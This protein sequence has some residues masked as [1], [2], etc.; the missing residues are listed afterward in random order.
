VPGAWQPDSQNGPIAQAQNFAAVMAQQ[1]QWLGQVYAV[2]IRENAS[3]ATY[4]MMLSA[5]MEGVRL[6]TDLTKT[7]I[8]K[9]G[10]N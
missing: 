5:K 3:R 1:T 10:G 2:S 9:S 6:V 7:A 8:Q 4:H